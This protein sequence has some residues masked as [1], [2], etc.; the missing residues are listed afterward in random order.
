MRIDPDY[1]AA[2]HREL[3]RWPGASV[4]FSIG[5]VHPVAHLTFAKHT[6]RVFFPGTPGDSRRGRDN[7]LKDVRKELRALG[8]VRASKPL[9]EPVDKPYRT[10]R[11]PGLKPPKPKPSESKPDNWLETLQKL[12]AKLS[13]SN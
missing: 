1:E 10:F 13:G 9:S 2:C 3:T 12:H 8:A 4:E 7:F 6:R 5:G 11:R